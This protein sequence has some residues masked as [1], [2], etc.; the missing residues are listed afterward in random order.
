MSF[1]QQ[2]PT[3]NDSTRTYAEPGAR[4]GNGLAVAALVLGILAV[5]LFWTV[6]GGLVLGLLAL[7]FGI[8][9]AR[10]AR[11][12]RAPHGTMAVV[13]AVLGALGLI[14]SAV[15]VA[16]GA[17]VLDSDEFKDFDDC[18]RHA[19]TQSERDACAEDFN[20]DINN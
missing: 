6:V 9:G 15:I 5:L 12:G 10:R 8:V 7:V 1:S 3:G 2:P 20:R 17:S 16:I 11:G 14:V 4:R 13:G 18:V 19:D